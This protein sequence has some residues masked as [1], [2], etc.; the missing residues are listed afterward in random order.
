MEENKKFTPDKDII[1]QLQSGNEK[2]ILSVVETLMSSGKAG[3]LPYLIDLAHATRFDTVKSQIFRLLNQLKHKKATTYLADAIR[4]EQYLSIRKELVEACWQNG[5]DFAPHFSLFTDLMIHGSEEI[6]FE[7]FT[8][9]E[10]MGYIPENN[11]LRKEAAKIKSHLQETKGRKR[12]V[13][14]ETL[15]MMEDFLTH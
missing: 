15:R 1:K 10:N 13:L 3:Y 14:D 9:I 6:A 2:T 4:N 12:Y 8:V 5:L 11:L 7:A